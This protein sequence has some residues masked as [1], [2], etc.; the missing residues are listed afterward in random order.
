[1]IDI[2]IYITH[3]DWPDYVCRSKQ[4]IDSVVLAAKELLLENP[5]IKAVTVRE[6][7]ETT[8]DNRTLIQ[9]DRYDA[10]FELDPELRKAYSACLVKK[11]NSK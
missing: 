5:K 2:Y 6:V 9:H 1:M 3:Y 11:G 7:T 8:I 10:V 4:D